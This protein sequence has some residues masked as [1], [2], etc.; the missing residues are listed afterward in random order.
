[1]CQKL[2]V[3]CSCPLTASGLVSASHSAARRPKLLMDRAQSLEPWRGVVQECTDAARHLQCARHDKRDRQRGRL[4]FPQETNHSS[5]SEIVRN[6]VG[7][8]PS[9]PAS[10]PQ[11]IDQSFH[12]GRN[13]R[14]PW[15]TEGFVGSG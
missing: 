1:M 4:V 7:K 12:L 8:R 6:V 13:R 14:N 10:C 2:T 3:P 15:E 5:R 9:D 11:G